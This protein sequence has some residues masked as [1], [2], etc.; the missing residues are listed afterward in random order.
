MIQKT[1]KR[2]AIYIFVQLIGAGLLSAQTLTHGPVVGGV[3]SSTAKVF[4]RTDQSA[5]VQI[6]YG[7][8]PTL[9]TYSSS[10]TVNSSKLSDYTEIIG[11]S[12]LKAETTYYLNPVVNGVGQLSAPFP[13]FKTFAPASAR[14]DFSFAI[15]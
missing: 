1:F 3:T 11:L 5:S 12:R 13:S 10:S 14:R 6:R 7:T 8:D 4:V 2:T 9:Q 15:L